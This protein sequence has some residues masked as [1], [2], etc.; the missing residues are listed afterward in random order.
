MGEQ[1]LVGGVGLLYDFFGLGNLI[2]QGTIIICV[3]E[4]SARLNEFDLIAL[5]KLESQRSDKRVACKK[6]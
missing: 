4:A 5:V 6:L 1:G 3:H 2:E